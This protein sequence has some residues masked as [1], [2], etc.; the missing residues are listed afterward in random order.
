M[1]AVKCRANLLK[2]KQHQE[3]KPTLARIIGK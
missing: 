3:R 2:I 1:L